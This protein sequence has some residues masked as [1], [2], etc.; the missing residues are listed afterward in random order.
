[1]RGVFTR[2]SALNHSSQQHDC[3]IPLWGHLSPP[4]NR[5]GTASRKSSPREVLKFF[6]CSGSITPFARRGSMTPVYLRSQTGS[7]QNAV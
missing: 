1:M 3:A 2:I 4:F 6:S 7:D 5:R